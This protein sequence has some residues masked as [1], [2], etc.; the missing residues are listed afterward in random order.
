M[1]LLHPASMGKFRAMKIDALARYLQ[2]GAKLWNLV[3]P[4]GTT[5]WSIEVLPGK[6]AAEPQ[7]W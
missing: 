4:I 5:D 7:H 2:P 3:L 6:V 1:R